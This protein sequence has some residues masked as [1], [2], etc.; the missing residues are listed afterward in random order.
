MLKRLINDWIIP[1]AVAAVIALAINKFLFFQVSVPTESMYPT[2][3]PGD[4]II[5]TRVHNVQNLKRGDIVVFYSDELHET[6]IKRLIGLPGDEIEIKEDG[7][8]YVNDQR[9]DEPYVVN[10]DNKTG[11]YRVPE[12][13][14]FFLGDNRLQSKDARY[15]INHYISADDIQ[16]KA[17]Y[18]IFPFNR[19][20]PLK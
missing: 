8:V 6:L 12:N 1:I 4:R 18:I 5:V 15:W 3:K 13:S 9:L 11:R 19:F 16:G 7:T 10:R 20:G 14:Y 2:I 17:R